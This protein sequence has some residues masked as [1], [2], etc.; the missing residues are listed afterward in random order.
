[1]RAEP[2]YYRK[3]M[4]LTVPAIITN[5]INAAVN[6]ADVL[7]L[8]S[9]G[10]NEVSASSLANQ[11]SSITYFF[12]FGLGT[13]V[14]MLGAQYF[15]K[16]DHKTVERIEGIALR[17]AV[18]IAS[19]VAVCSLLIP[20]QMMLVYTD[21]SE[22]IELGMTYL[23]ITA[24]GLVFWSITEVYLATLRC[25]G[26]MAI[27]TVAEALSLGTNVLLNAVFIFGWFG[28]P[29]LGIAGVAMATA[30]SRLVELVLCL[31]VSLTSRDLKL[32][33]RY[34]FCF[35]QVLERDF[36]K[37][38]VPAILNDV[39]WGIAYSAYSAILGHISGDAVAANSFVSMVRNFGTAL[40]YGIATTT[41]VM[42][43]Q[44]LGAGKTEEAKRHA[45]L[46][47]W[48][49]V[50]AAAIGGIVIAVLT[51][52]A[53]RF[54][55]LT[56]N[57]A[58]LL[59]LMLRINIFYIFG[60]AVNTT[61]ICGVFRSGGDSR[62]G[63]RCDT[64]TMWLY[65]VPLGLLAAFVLKLDVAIVYMLL[66]TDE[67]VKWPWVLRHFRKDEWARNITRPVNPDSGI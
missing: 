65:A 62:F 51:P 24:P 22:L 11:Y 43:G 3:L 48:I 57:A 45:R 9:V 12:F 50:A 31:F 17:Y 14:S 2:E 44:E 41:A 4:R 66:C 42:L 56:D 5:L 54:A 60:T 64:I 16:G 19:L 40:C 10:Q 28:A 15:G 36:M 18:L 27:C 67:F 33:P 52:V 58:A 39:I 26:R 47:L 20:R 25:A 37:M 55:N 6:Y 59:E 30:I 1:M 34:A 23:R 8:N 7:M 38:A 61:L 29:K 63:F 49:S 21:E 32:R 46:F 13:G 35:T 53:L